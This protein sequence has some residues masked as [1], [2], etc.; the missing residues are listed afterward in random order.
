MGFSCYIF[1]M[2]YEPTIGLEIHVELKTRTKMFCNSLN[3]PNETHPNVN[4]CP[5]CMAHPGT[6]PTANQEAIR[7]L[8]KVG[9]ALHCSI[10]EFSKFDRKNYFYPDI[11][12]GYQ[13]SQ[14]DLPLCYDGYIEVSADN[15]ERKKIRIQRIHMEEDTGRLAHSADGR[16]SYIDY[17]RAGVPLM[18]LVTHPDIKSAKEIEQFVKELQLVLRYVEASDV[19]MEKGQ[20]RVEVNISVRKTDD[21]NYGTKVEIKNINSIS[22]AMK[23]AD[24][25]MAR[26]AEALE[27]GEKI[28]QETRGW[29]DVHLRT[30]SQR[31]KETSA[32]YRY[33]P[34]PDIPPLRFSK[35]E[36]HAI[37][38][39][40]PELPEHRRIRFAKQ[41]H[42]NESQIEIFTVAK[43]LGGYF[44]NVVSELDAWDKFADHLKKPSAEHFQKL[45]ALAANYLITE[46][47]ALFNMNAKEL[48]DLEGIAISPS[49]FAEVVVRLFHNEISSTSAKI[50]LKEIAATGDSPDTIIKQ[51]DLAQVSDQSALLEAVAEVITK[52]EGPV[53]DYKKGKVEVLKFLVGQVMAR[54]KGKANPQVVAEML[55][56][57]LK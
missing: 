27:S 50:V 51:K 26:Q 24:F 49:A 38:A 31:S 15:G 21:P 35:E 36:V 13:I 40:L 32:Q 29:D 33:F 28:V 23:A 8:I 53:Q 19:D 37:K 22:A 47:P 11:P 3:D 55:A 54:T 25:E 39:Q 4:V 34:E 10:A 56:A 5:V 9:L 52:N 48:D 17:N 14:Y 41:Y 42:I 46:F 6:L 12:K 57:Q 18:E 44:E 45:H 7:K 20:L 43:H 2:Q 1:V 16:E 30:L